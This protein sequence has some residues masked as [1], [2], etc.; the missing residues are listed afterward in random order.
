MSET[1]ALKRTTIEKIFTN[2]LTKCE[3]LILLYVSR[4]TKKA[5]YCYVRN[6]KIASTFNIS[7]ENIKKAK[8]SLKS[9]SLIKVEGNNRITLPDNG[10]GYV[11]MQKSFIDLVI[12]NRF[13]AVELK[14]LIFIAKTDYEK[15]SEVYGR[16]FYLSKSKFNRDTRSGP[17]VVLK[18]LRLLIKHNMLTELDQKFENNIS[19]YANLQFQK[20]VIVK[21]EWKLNFNGG[22]S[23]KKG[24]RSKKCSEMGQNQW[25]T[26]GS[27]KCRGIGQNQASN[28]GQI[29]SEINN[30]TKE[31]IDKPVNE[32]EKTCRSLTSDS[33]VDACNEI[34]ERMK[35]SLCHRGINKDN[36]L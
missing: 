20:K 16:R 9:K 10:K 24:E 28:E 15:K 25:G 7:P 31:K 33:D 5:G 30:N 2:K 4:Y 29:R 27:K 13:T 21:R 17:A 19:W 3:T 14:A 22:K 1:F 6:G 26:D 32:T 23:W 18:I 11:P 36:N 35:N 34:L 12:V 8:S